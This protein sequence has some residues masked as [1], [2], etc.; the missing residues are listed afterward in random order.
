ME[1]F[2]LNL[3]TVDRPKAD[4][5]WERVLIM[6]GDKKIDR[7]KEAK[8]VLEYVLAALSTVL[9]NIEKI[10][11]NMQDTCKIHLKNGIVFSILGP[12][13]VRM[14][15]YNPDSLLEIMICQDPPQEIFFELKKELGFFDDVQQFDSKEELY[16]ILITAATK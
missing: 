6:F 14:K 13:S 5:E 16:N 7:S 15:Y 1:T 8:E 2:N 12:N 3:E 10:I 4:I 9:Q 11:Y